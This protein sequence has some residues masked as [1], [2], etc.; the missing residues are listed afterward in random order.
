MSVLSFVSRW[1]GAG[2]GQALVL[3]SEVILL[4]GKAIITSGQWLQAR[5]T[6]IVAPTAV[7]EELVF[8]GD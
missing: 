8:L 4:R 3:A 2:G 6:L 5:A 7:L 1:P